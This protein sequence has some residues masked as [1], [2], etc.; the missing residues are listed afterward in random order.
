[1]KFVNTIEAEEGIITA[2][3]KWRDGEQQ[4]IIGICYG[5]GM[6]IANTP[7]KL[8]ASYDC[9]SWS[10]TNSGMQFRGVVFGN[11]VFV[12]IS[13]LEG[14]YTRTSKDGF[15]WSAS[16]LQIS[17]HNWTSLCFGNGLFVAVSSDGYICTSPDGETWTE[18]TSSY[19]AQFSSVCYG[20]GG[21]LAVSEIDIDSNIDEKLLYSH[22]GLSWT[23]LTLS[24]PATPYKTHY[25]G[26]KYFVF[27]KN[28][29]YFLASDT[30]ESLS[31]ISTNPGYIPAAVAFSDGEYFIAFGS[32]GTSDGVIFSTKD[33]STFT[34]RHSISSFFLLTTKYGTSIFAHGL[35]YICGSGAKT[36][37]S[38]YRSSPPENI[39][40]K[41]IP[42]GVCELDATAKVPLSR[43]PDDYT[44]LD[45]TR[46]IGGSF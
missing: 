10:I 30:P 35:M 4:Q 18:N 26:G 9:A 22:D 34:L 41:G 25:R 5:N 27:L 39:V 16:N 23:P 2:G 29:E 17:K 13:A 40:I 32:A 8:L 44:G 31:V 33:L 36:L 37:I 7:T 43:L 28:S 45:I 15:T 21:F 1:M 19:T 24:L 20:F 42:G 3:L 38:G 12:A 14:G 6:F 11:G 46:I